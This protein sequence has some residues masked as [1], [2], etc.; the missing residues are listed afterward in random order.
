MGN[1]I[2]MNLLLG[3]VITILGMVFTRQL[4][5]LNSGPN[6]DYGK[7]KNNKAARE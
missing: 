1:L 7:E 3:A 6:Y 5:S 2:A 4:L